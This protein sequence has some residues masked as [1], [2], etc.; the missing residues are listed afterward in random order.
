MQRL[1]KVQEIETELQDDTHPTRWHHN[2]A[3]KVATL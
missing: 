1:V 2:G 3:T